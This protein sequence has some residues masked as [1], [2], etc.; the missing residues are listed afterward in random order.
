MDIR[1]LGGGGK[2]RDGLYLLLYYKLCGYYDE[3]LILIY[4]DTVTFNITFFELQG[5]DSSGCNPLIAHFCV[6]VSRHFNT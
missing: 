5:P 3:F 6:L 1:F 2:F 4:Y